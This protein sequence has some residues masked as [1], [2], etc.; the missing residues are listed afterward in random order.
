MSYKVLSTG[1]V[2][3]SATAKQLPTLDCKVAV[4]KAC[5]NNAASVYLGKSTATVADGTTD[6]T[7]GIELA[8]GDSI[9]L[10]LYNLNELYIIGANATDDITYI[11]MG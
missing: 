11:L 6:A 4:I 1:E 10:E 8:P 2:S 9:V 7:T 5:W 3:G